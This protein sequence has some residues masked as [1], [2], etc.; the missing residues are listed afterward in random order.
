M[1]LRLLGSPFG[2]PSL[3]NL[4]PLS[5]GCLAGSEFQFLSS[6]FCEMIKALLSFFVSQQLF[7]AWL[8]SP[9]TQCACTGKYPKEKSGMECW[10]RLSEFLLFLGSCKSWLK[11]FQCLRTGFFF[12]LILSQFCSLFSGLMLCHEIVC[13]SWQWDSVY[14]AIA[15]CSL[16]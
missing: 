7:S 11:S 4:G 9:C 12:L 15:A 13:S 10:A 2:F 8:L 5:P 1:R 3:L 14:S 6:H 16:L